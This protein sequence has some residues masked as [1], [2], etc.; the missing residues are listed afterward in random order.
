M[1][2]SPKPPQ[3]LPEEERKLALRWTK[4]VNRP[5]LAPEDLAKPHKASPKSPKA[6]PDLQ[7]WRQDAPIWRLEE[8]KTWRAER[9]PDWL[10]VHDRD[11]C[12]LQKGD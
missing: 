11:G 4:H 9:T 12:A 6:S 2:A 5:D 7:I 1:K 3:S 8:L 10:P